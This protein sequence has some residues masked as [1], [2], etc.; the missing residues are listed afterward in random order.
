M[1]ISLG[2]GN[3][4][5]IVLHQLILEKQLCLLT[6]LQMQT[7]RHDKSTP[8]PE[9]STGK[10]LELYGNLCKLM[11]CSVLRCCASSNGCH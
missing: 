9:F 10:I 3:V 8:I 2:I 5:L 1:Y 7:A 11:L 4:L 6:G